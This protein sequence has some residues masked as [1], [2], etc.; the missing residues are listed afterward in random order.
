MIEVKGGLKHSAHI[1]P[2]RT[3]TCYHWPGFAK[4]GLGAERAWGHQRRLYV[5]KADVIE[6][7]RAAARG[8][9]KDGNRKMAK[10]CFATARRIKRTSRERDRRR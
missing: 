10:L 6:G 4:E 9:R 1:M 3:C 5:T 8:Y 2:A 7:W